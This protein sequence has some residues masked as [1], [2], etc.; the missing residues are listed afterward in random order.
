M[1]DK[2]LKQEAC[3]LYIEQEIETKLEEGKSAYAIGKELAK[4]VKRLF[5]AKVPPTT[6]EKRAQRLRTNVRSEL[7]ENTDKLKCPYG[8]IKMSVEKSNTTKYRMTPARRKLF[9]QAEEIG[10]EL[11]MSADD[12]IELALHIFTT[13]Q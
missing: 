3:Q 8:Q 6:L 9:L 10:S 2:N 1:T 4:E 13:K 5:E 11:K 7:A 12:V